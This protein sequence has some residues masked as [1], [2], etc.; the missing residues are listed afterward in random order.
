MG[1]DLAHSPY[2]SRVVKITTN[3]DG[4]PTIRIGEGVDPNAV[5]TEI[6]AVF[7]NLFAQNQIRIVLDLKGV[8][9]PNSS[10]IAMTVHRAVEARRQ[11]GDVIVANMGGTARQHFAMFSP[12]TFLSVDPLDEKTEKN[13]RTSAEPQFEEGKPSRIQV[14]ASVGDIGRAVDFVVALAGNAGFDKL[15]TSKLK[16][17]VYEACMNIIEHGYKFEPLKSIDVEVARE[18]DLF[19][20]TIRDKGKS[21]DAYE[22]KKYDVRSMIEDKRDGG[23]GLYII[24]RSVDRI[25][26]ETDPEKGNTLRLIKR[27]A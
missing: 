20:V 3:Q 8:R 19:A 12:L 13:P 18:E 14:E 24:R 25:E 27:I 1:R 21:F 10:F 6:Q 15:E 2:D 16:I 23:F 4:L 11:G 26:Y 9:F 22:E 17:A 7:D 5:V